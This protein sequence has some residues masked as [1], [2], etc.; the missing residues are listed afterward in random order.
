[1]FMIGQSFVLVLYDSSTSNMQTNYV[2]NYKSYV[3][4]VNQ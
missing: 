4:N 2:T 3:W 1:M